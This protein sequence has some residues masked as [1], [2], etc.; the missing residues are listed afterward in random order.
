MKKTYLMID[1]VETLDIHH[2]LST[3]YSN[4]KKPMDIHVDV[5]MCAI[6]NMA[7]KFSQFC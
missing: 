5:F 4:V 2:N 7:Q 6:L 3:E 1:M